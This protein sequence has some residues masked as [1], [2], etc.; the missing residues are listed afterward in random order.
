MHRPSDREQILAELAIRL[1]ISVERIA[2]SDAWQ[3]FPDQRDSLD[4]IELVF[5]LER[6]LDLP[7]DGHG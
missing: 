6:E 3:S 7:R 1:R 5:A 2:T 4:Y